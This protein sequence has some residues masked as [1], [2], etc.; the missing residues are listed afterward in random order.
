MLGREGSCGASR[1]C[2][3]W[4]QHHSI[5]G[6]G[7]G[8]QRSFFMRICSIDGCVRK[9]KAKG[10]CDY[11]YLVYKRY[12][13]PL[14]E[15]RVRENHGL[16]DHY[17]YEI[18]AKMKHRCYNPDSML[19]HRYGGR[20]IRVCDRWLHSFT[21]FLKDMGDRPFHGAELDRSN[22]DGDYSPKNCRW[23]T[24]EENNQNTS[25]TKLSIYKA[26]QI[27]KMYSTGKYYYKE[28]ATIFSV[29]NGAIS[30]VLNNRSWRNA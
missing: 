23:A 1:P 21:A 4:P 27:R 20:G 7:G 13:D 29:S 17:L 12:G 15:V 11:H 3:R 16:R 18:W 26:I 19:Y 22:N 24:H 2:I 10:F 25:R 28:L 14:T 5:Q 8:H 6:S 9:H 30:K